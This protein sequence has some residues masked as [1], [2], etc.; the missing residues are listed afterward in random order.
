M[1]CLSPW[2]SITD[3]S[4]DGLFGHELDSRWT[5]IV[6]LLHPK[7]SR[8]GVKHLSM[9]YDRYQVGD[10]STIYTT[11]VQT[12]VTEMPALIPKMW[13]LIYP[14]DLG[15]WLGLMFLLPLASF[16]IYYFMR[17]KIFFDSP[18]RSRWKYVQAICE[19]QRSNRK[20]R[21]LVLLLVAVRDFH[22]YGLQRCF[23]V[24]SNSA[25]KRKRRPDCCGSES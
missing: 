23:L 10:F 9:N 12:F 11:Q 24:V 19:A 16:V 17:K 7:Q 20:L 8:H 2:D 1:E 25:F 15:V 18:H 5:G 3:G 6:G 14:F 4:E 13:V 22:Y 21:D